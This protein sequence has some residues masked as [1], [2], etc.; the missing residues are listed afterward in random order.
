MEEVGLVERDPVEIAKMLRDYNA[1]MKAID[2]IDLVHLGGEDGAAVRN[3]LKQFVIQESVSELLDFLQPGSGY[4]YEKI[5][6]I[7][8]R[9]RELF[10]ESV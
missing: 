9:I 4:K 1:R 6:D 5:L 3:L 2:E 8:P 7:M 10:G